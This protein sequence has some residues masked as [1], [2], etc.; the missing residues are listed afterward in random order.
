MAIVVLFNK[1]TTP[2][3]SKQISSHG[4][5]RTQPTVTHGP[6]AHRACWSR[7]MSSL[8]KWSGSACPITSAR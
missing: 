6:N 3:V 5:R 2:A 4:L 7:G 8:V 1:A